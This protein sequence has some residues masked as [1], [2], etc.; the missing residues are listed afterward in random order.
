M[1]KYPECPRFLSKIRNGT[2][3][4][5]ENLP[6]GNNQIGSFNNLQTRIGR[7]DLSKALLEKTPVIL[8]AYA[9]LEWEKEEKLLI[10]L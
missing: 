1:D 9:F 6:F 5:G 2:V 8:N 7:K 10:N 4:D 3:L